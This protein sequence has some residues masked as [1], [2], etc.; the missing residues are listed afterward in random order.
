LELILFRFLNKIKSVIIE[1]VCALFFLFEGDFM[2]KYTIAAFIM[3]VFYLGAL[4]YNKLYAMGSKKE[5]VLKEEVQDIN[6]YGGKSKKVDYKIVSEKINLNENN[7]SEVYKEIVKSINTAGV[8]RYPDS[9]RGE[10][11]EILTGE[12]LNVSFPEPGEYKVEIIE[13]PYLSRSSVVVKNQNIFFETG[14]QGE[15]ILNVTKDGMFYKRFRVNSKL[16]YSFTQEKNYDIILNSYENEKL[17]ILLTSV[18]LSRVA[19]P[20]ALYHKDT[21]FMILEKTLVSK[22][23]AEAEEAAKF[24][25][26]NFQLDFMEKKQLFYFDMEIAKDDPFK[27]RD[28]LEKNIHEPGFSDKLVNIILSGKTLREKDELFLKKTY[29]ETLNPEIAVYLGKW[30]MDKGNIIDAERY[31]IYGKEYYTLCMLYLQ[32]EDLDRFD[33]TLSKV[34]EDKVPQLKKEREIYHRAKLI[35]KEV[36]LGD[37][38]YQGENYEEAVLFYKRAEEKDIE[39]ARKLGTDMKIGMSYYYITRYEDAAN[40]FE[41]AMESEKTPM[42]KAEIAYLTGVCYYRMQDKEKSMKTFEKL[43]KDYPG[44]TWSK[45]AMVYIIRLR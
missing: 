13:S 44:T 6:P 11:Y 14:Y 18:K 12:T 22:K 38:K 17:D 20:D 10:D 43:A 3:A 2:K 40:Y 28:F 34:S 41:K 36:D 15:Y 27:Y 9:Y 26:N 35:K 42:K 8:R 30:Y 37:E 31:L 25:R 32:N 5:K 45:K 23:M 19:F 24:I 21:A 29:S 4:P 16:K 7:V 33:V 1:H 39:A